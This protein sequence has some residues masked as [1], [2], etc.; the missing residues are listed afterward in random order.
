VLDSARHAFGRSK[1]GRRVAL[2]FIGCALLPICCLA[3]VAYVQVTSELRD[4]G[5]SRLSQVAKTAGVELL[6]KLIGLD[7]ELDLLNGMILSRDSGGWPALP[8]ALRERFTSRLSGLALVVGDDQPQLMF[9]AMPP[10][11]GVSAKAQAHMRNGHSAL[12]VTAR[13]GGPPRIV[14]MRAL[15]AN[16]NRGI[17]VAEVDRDFLFSA[18][19]APPQINLVVLGSELPLFSSLSPEQSQEV[20]AHRPGSGTSTGH[21]QWSDSDQAYAASFWSI[22]MTFDFLVP[23][24]TV[25]AT[26]ANAEVLA[27]IRDARV[28][29]TLI[30]LLSLWLVML[31]SISQVRRYLVPLQMLTENTA[32]IGR[33]DFDGHLDIRSGDEFEEVAASFNS[34]SS[35]LKRQF[36]TLAARVELDRAVLSSLEIP[37]IVGRV[38]DWL[39][40]LLAGDAFAVIVLDRPSSG[41]A[42]AFRATRSGIS[43]P[44]AEAITITPA[45]ATELTSGDG[46]L[47]V[48]RGAECPGYLSALGSLPW[49]TCT[50]LPIES[51][52]QLVGVLA[53]AD[54]ELRQRSD[55]DMQLARQ[56]ADQ[57]GVAL[58][59]AS[60]VEALDRLNV[61]TLM[62]LARTVDAK[63][64]WTAGHSQRVTDLASAI[65]RGMGLTAADLDQLARATLL[66][67]IGKIA[68]P[69]SILN[70]PGPL[71][72]EEFAVMQTHP[73]V[74]ARILEP[75][76]DY[77][78]LIPVVL[79]HHE[80]F[81]GTGYPAGLAGDAISLDARIVA[82]ADVFDA[83]TSE[84]PYRKAMDETEA[85]RI[86]MN[87]RG[88]A[89]DPSAVDAFLRIPKHSR[90]A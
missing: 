61:G 25:V 72:A 26:Q 78:R 31:L 55:D 75:I 41:P 65:G 23:G 74:G 88:S 22:P 73:V 57:L 52:G 3:V 15:D 32:R 24:W 9:G 67:D 42:R 66:H 76:P 82:V 71:T 13:D 34:M 43:A 37:E 30:A 62:A 4:A 6:D 1:V 84:R 46:W 70:K 48:T 16:A 80:R 49:T 77:D 58:S 38:L 45:Q 51:S 20:Y 17:V 28:S 21:F 33:G 40:R 83:L 2:L 63:S 5:Q 47:C 44:I 60:L 11:S 56:L 10:Y 36:E 69:S 8:P 27:P 29:F 35:Q 19:L 53:L 50:L 7:A 39:P 85:T 64:P 18:D 59:N 86:I 54:N 87:G 81:D 90:A 12:T 79:Q 89:F 68:V 14:V